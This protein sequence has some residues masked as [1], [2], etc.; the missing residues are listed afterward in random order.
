MNVDFSLE[1]VSLSSVAVHE[2]RFYELVLLELQ[3]ARTR[4][5]HAAANAER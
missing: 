1:I 3:L 2:G 5:I 4:L